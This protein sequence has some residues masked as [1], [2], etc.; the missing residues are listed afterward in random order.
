MFAT[1][2]AEHRRDLQPYLDG[3][4]ARH[5]RQDRCWIELSWVLA[6]NRPLNSFLRSIV[7][8][9]AKTY[10]IYGKDIASNRLE[11]PLC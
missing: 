2:L 8:D 1:M 10:R 9:P 4:V 11:S 3:V 6:S 7:G 5:D